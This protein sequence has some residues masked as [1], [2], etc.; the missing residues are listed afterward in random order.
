[1]NIRLLV[2][3]RGNENKYRK[4]AESLGIAQAV[5]FAGTQVDR[6]ERYYRAADVFIL[7]SR[8]DTFGM[9]VLEAM[10][11]GL[12]V[13]VSPNVGAKDLVEEG[14]NGF[15]LREP[16][17]ADSAADRMVRLLDRTR[18]EAMGEAAGQTAAM[19]DWEKLTDK[20]EKIYESFFIQ[21]K[22]SD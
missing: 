7:L 8:F 1:M 3:G 6:L 17:D 19:H 21:S 5:T 13:I 9:V 15:I 2:V 18:R 14:V 16:S 10:A 11:A 22:S 20:M 12:P 4:M